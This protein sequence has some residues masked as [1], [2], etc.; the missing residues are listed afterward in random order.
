MTQA[1]LEAHMG[2][3]TGNIQERDL[4]GNIWEKSGLQTN[5]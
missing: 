4:M 2:E 1:Q 3:R 5:L